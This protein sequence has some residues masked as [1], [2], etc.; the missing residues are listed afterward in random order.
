MKKLLLAIG[1][2]VLAGAIF[3][4]YSGM[5]RDFSVLVFSKT[6]G[7]RHASIEGGKLA[8]LKLGKEYG[9]SV[10]TTEDA[11]FFDEKNLKN[12]KVVVF[13]NTTENILNEKQQLEFNRFIQAGGGFVGIHAAADTEYDWPWYGDLV[14]AYF[15]SHPNDPNVRSAKL[16][17]QNP[18][19]ESTNHLPEVWERKDE[20]YN[21][22]NIK[23]HINVLI[24]IDETSYEGGENKDF[25]PMA[26]YH[27]FDGGRAFYTAL[28]H[29]KESYHDP[30]FLEH[31]WGG[32]SYAAG[33]GDP[34]NYNLSSVAPEE[35]R[36]T[37]VVLDQNLHEPM[38]L[39]FLTE[40]KL[41]FIERPGNIKL[42][43]FEKGK[44]EIVDKIEVH[45]EFEDGLLGLAV[46]PDYARNNWIYLFYSPQ[47]KVAKQHVSRFVFKDDKLDKSTEKVLLEIPVQRLECCHAAGSL[48]FGPD[49]LLYISTGDDTNPFE[50]EGYNPIDERED[51]S[52]WDAQKSSAN[53]N[54][55]RGKILR[56]K[57]EPDGT[58]S[59]P[60][61]NL[62]ARDGSEGRPEIYIMGCRN[63]FRISIDS[64]TKFLYWGDVGP[65]AGKDSITRGP[66]GYDEVNQARRSGNYGWPYLIANNKAYHDFNFSDSNAGPAFNP[67]KSMNDS[68]NNT[69]TKE[70]PPAQPAMIWYPYD[71]SEDFPL[72]G[73]GGRNAMAGPVYHY[74]N[75]PDN[76]N[77]FPEYYDG[78]LLIYDWMRGW[79]KVVSFDEDLKFSKM[80]DFLPGIVLNNPVDMIFSPGGELYLLEYG[81]LW[82][83]QNL[84]ARL[85]HI[86]YTA[87][88]RKPVARIY[89]DD[90]VG[91]T[92]LT[93]NFSAKNTVD[94]DGDS[95]AYQWK[96]ADDERFGIDA[97]YTF[98]NPGI[99]K[100]KLTVNDPQGLQGEAEQEIIVGN[101][102]A[103]IRWVLEG[104]QTFYWDNAEL[105]YRVEVE[106]TEDGVLGEGSISAEKVYVSFDYLQNGMDVTESMQG[107]RD[108]LE[109]SK[110]MIGKQLMERSDCSACHQKESR[111]VGPSYLEI[112]KKYAEDP[113][114]YTGYLVSRII[115]GGGGVWGDNA[116]AAHP[117]LSQSDAEKMVEYILSLS[118]GQSVHKGFPVEGAYVF[119]EHIDKG[120]EGSYVLT[121][122]YTDRGGVGIGPLTARH[123]LMLRHPKI[124]AE[125]FDMS[126]KI[127]VYEVKAEDTPGVEQDF[128]I[129]VGN[130]G[131]Y[132]GFED[133]DLTGVQSIGMRIGHV[134]PHTRGGTVELRLDGQQGK[135]IGEIDLGITDLGLKVRHIDLDDVIRGKHNI[136]FNFVSED[137]GDKPVA[138]VDW[139]Y[140][141]NEKSKA[142]S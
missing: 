111:S 54:D 140:F 105:L 13:L 49:G 121:A 41:I 142:A 71:A 104:N 126:N 120:E 4:F 114:K 75:Y 94:Y 19:H 66:R 112:S 137:S 127:T 14:G 45:T 74:G 2:L 80:E 7:Y 73:T 53:T 35:N 1:L 86:K 100:V 102:L 15:K 21:F 118:S 97:K 9:F 115:K 5:D 78:K 110:G 128:V 64:R 26:W 18:D 22:Y 77:K 125:N 36:F 79:I 138:I 58:Y 141:S 107:H 24:T 106:D 117:Q 93:V 60:E 76:E 88:N 135:M 113:K 6:E 27:E 136:Y 98:A 129:V 96:F 30:L 67:E 72:V 87:G 57:P 56:I 3:L 32:I 83:A 62:F 85:V 16:L 92:P 29:T 130:A 124:Q 108:W 61:E 134:V 89:A 55:L 51:R 43:D 31:I 70:L 65:D 122:S 63:P 59:I 91:T 40:K 116:M 68:P 101:D 33:N 39:D 81:T 37:K 46:D 20:W 10:D 119:R 69:G 34:V 23:D 11:S 25:H 38:E 131:K 133:I 52:P 82:F 95:L 48:E 50:S 99:Y 8:L 84:D 103:D 42:Y 109:S 28:G 139:V 12:Y 44:T 90:I 123:T 132:F 17:V 47:G